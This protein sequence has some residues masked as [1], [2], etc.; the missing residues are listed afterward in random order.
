MSKRIAFFRPK[1]IP[2]PNVI[3]AEILASHFTDHEIDVIDIRSLVRPRLDILAI[4]TL[5]VI[6]MYGRDILSGHKKFEVAFWRTPFIFHAI[7]RLLMKRVEG[8][9][10]EFTF[11]MQSI[12]DCSLPNVR[13]FIYTDHT[14]LANLTY[15]D[16]DRRRLYSQAWIDL[17]KQIYE[18]ATRIF[19]RSTN[20][21]H[22]LIEQYG[23]PGE[24]VKCVYAGSN[25]EVDPS[26][27]EGKDYSGQNIVFV[28][29]DWVRKGGPELIEAFELVLEK[30]PGATLTIVGTSPQV[31]TRNTKIMG[32]LPLQALKP[33]YE[34]G[35]IF[36]MPSHVEPFGIVFL[37][38][39]QAR[40][41]I[42]STRVGALPDLVEDGWNGWLVE[43]GDVQGI[44]D[45]L[46][47]LLAN[48]ELCRQFGERNLLLT[49]E[50]YSWKAVGER[51]RTHI[52]EALS[53]EAET[54][55]F[56]KTAGT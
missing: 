12:F 13:H 18:N 37:E 56:H 10:Y 40:L 42:V 21:R 38:A 22:L 53:G 25:V 45:A 33:I 26:L 8:I 43:P 23:Q 50:R 3:V 29:M 16:F 36:C 7:K 17:E 32:K 24:K 27:T 31:Q 6:W 1:S 54:S 46:S 34:A 2:L 41:P 51:F 30:H 4:N 20:I 9:E 11:Q 55:A 47:K 28:G 14:H 52:L 5:S 44:A 35:T 19:V 48:P 39:M 49:Q 15:P